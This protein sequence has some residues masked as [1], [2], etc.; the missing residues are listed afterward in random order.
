[1]KMGWDKLSSKKVLKISYVLFGV[2]ALYA[3]P[4]AGFQI[5]HSHN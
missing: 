1:M 3:D 2:F 5:V 4:A